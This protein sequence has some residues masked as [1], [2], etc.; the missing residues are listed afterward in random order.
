[1]S[2]PGPLT[3]QVGQ[4]VQVD[5]SGMQT[6]E[7]V[8][9]PGTIVPGTVTH[10]DTEQRLTIRLDTALGGHVL[11]TAPVGRIRSIM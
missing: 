9:G 5:A 10:I 1:M 4:R 8:V 2:A 6:P 3:P 11:V 7:G